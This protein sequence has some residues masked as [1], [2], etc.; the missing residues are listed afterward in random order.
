LTLG[1][2]DALK[3]SLAITGAIFTPCLLWVAK[4]ISEWHGGV[5]EVERARLDATA[6][7]L[8]KAVYHMWKR[9]AA[10][11]ELTTSIP[12]AVDLKVA[13]SRISA[14][15]AQWSR[16]GQPLMS[17]PRQ[18]AIGQA[19]IDSANVAGATI[20]MSV[21]YNQIASGRLV[22]LG[23]PGSGKTAAAVLLLLA[24]CTAR[25][26]D[27]PVPVLFSLATWQ[28]NTKSIQAWMANQLAINYRTSAKVG[29]A[30]VDDG[31]ILP[32]LDGLDELPNDQ[33]AEAMAGLRSLANV[34]LVL[35]CRTVEY[36]AAVT[37]RIV[38]RAAVVEV[39]PVGRVAAVSYLS[40]SGTA[41]VNRWMPLL[42]TLRDPTPN[43][44]RIALSSPL[45][46]SLCRLVYQSPSSN[47]VELTTYKTPGQIEDRLLDGLIPAVYGRDITDT[48]P[49][50]AQR[51]LIF[52]AK[53]LD[54]LGPGEIAWWRLCY[55][56][57]KWYLRVTAALLIGWIS[58][59]VGTIFF[60]LPAEFRLAVHQRSTIAFLLIACA[61]PGVLAGAIAG[62][63]RTAP[64]SWRRSRTKRL[65]RAI[66]GGLLCGAMV[67]FLAWVSL[68]A[69]GPG[70]YLA[71][72][73]LL[74]VCIVAV[75]LGVAV[76]VAQGYASLATG[77]VTPLDSFRTDRRSGITAGAIGGL[78]VGCLMTTLS[79]LA[80]LSESRPVL[81]GVL[82]GFSVGA[83]LGIE[84]FLW[85]AP[86]RSAAFVYS[87]AA[88]AMIHRDQLP[89]RLLRFLEDAHR[90]GVL[91]QSGM[92]YE[93]RHARLAGHL[94]DRAN[95][96]PSG[97]SSAAVPPSLKR[98]PQSTL[99]VGGVIVAL[100]T[101]AFPITLGLAG[102]PKPSGCVPPLSFTGGESTVKSRISV[103]KH[104]LDVAITPD[105]RR[106]YVTNYGPEQEEA[107]NGDLDTVSVIDLASDAVTATVQAGSNPW[108]VAITPNG[109]RAYIVAT[110]T[111]KVLD[112]STNTITDSIPVGA[113]PQYVAI[114]PNGQRVY[115][116][117]WGSDDV[118]VIDTAT[119]AVTDTV[120]VG[121]GPGAIAISQDGHHA[122][123]LNRDSNDVSVIDTVSNT[124]SATVPVGQTPRGIA[125]TPSSGTVYVTGS[126]D[127]S[128][129]DTHSNNV[130]ANLNLNAFVSGVSLTP[131]GRY[132]YV[133]CSAKD[134]DGVAVIDTTDNTVVRS[135]PVAGGS[136]LNVAITRDGRYAYITCYHADIVTVIDT[137]A[138]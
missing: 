49:Q 32:F 102:A 67:A 63:A 84:V 53:H 76:G 45:M 134:G 93:F 103:G 123:V 55:C 100:A 12:I 54:I 47:P 110:D 96:M 48:N 109:G 28:P 23:G 69:T 78:G 8:A 66:V 128:V 86:Q 118:S 39:E 115:V 88:T 133:T 22:I 68:R 135:I 99:V 125:V 90:R 31:R 121:Q 116:T 10:N 87:L 7:E 65:G 97:K 46:L 59:L 25:R 13:D 70:S 111:V 35:T 129:I 77:A 16:S 5:A 17:R 38:E 50:T 91:R 71:V 57:P 1:G 62:R 106:A 105:G 18:H 30:L 127:V 58:T 19:R 126:R 14:H 61:L 37:E 80:Y 36:T 120:S 137:S 98:P 130:I 34:P 27:D 26:P 107:R 138:D 40:H 85:L 3:I 114:S 2:P 89:I 60:I 108:G 74:V 64:S 11:R 112:T 73:P 15:H 20:D 43:P 124:I 21:L 4:G 29:R 117:N 9:E 24:R 56:V 122:F 41:D 136:P 95:S 51:W 92:T 52:L 79:A 101:L 131:D 72:A 119:N 42:E 6:E 104:P 44:C 75:P 113:V 132:A 83:L 81:E 33:L 82:F 94:K